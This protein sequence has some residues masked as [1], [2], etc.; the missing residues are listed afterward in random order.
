MVDMTSNQTKPLIIKVIE[1]IVDVL[2]V[3]KQ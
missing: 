1:L 3:T 2:K